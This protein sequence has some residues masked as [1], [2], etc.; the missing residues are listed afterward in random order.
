MISGQQN[1]NG[2]ALSDISGEVISSGDENK[3]QN[4]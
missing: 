2:G 4:N 1:L 3:M